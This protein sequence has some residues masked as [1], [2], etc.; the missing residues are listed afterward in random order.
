VIPRLTSH[1]RRRLHRVLAPLLT[2]LVAVGGLV[3]V[4]S[5]AQAGEEAVHVRTVGSYGGAEDQ[6][7]E[8]SDIAVGPNGHVYVAD[9]DKRRIV[10]LAADGTYLRSV[11]ANEAVYGVDVDA[12]GDIY[13]MGPE[14]VSKYASSDGR[15]LYQEPWGGYR[16]FA[17]GD[18]GSV[19]F[20][21]DWGTPGIIREGPNGVEAAWLP[22]ADENGP[23]PSMSSYDV[24]LTWSAGILHVTDTKVGRVLRVTS[25][26]DYVPPLYPVAPPE[27]SWLT[28]LAV[29]RMGR[30]AATTYGA[31]ATFGSDWQ[32][33]TGWPISEPLDYEWPRRVAYG[34]DGLVYTLTN[35]SRIQITRVGRAFDDFTPQITGSGRAGEELTVAASTAPE[36]ASWS[37]AWTVSGS[38]EVR[39]TTR[40]FTPTV[41]DV[42]RTVSVAVTAKGTDGSPSD[43]TST[44]SRTVAPAAMT[45]TATLSDSTPAT[46]PTTGDVLSVDLD[47]S[48]LPAGATSAIRWGR[49]EAG[50]CAVAG[51]AHDTYTVRDADA[52]ATLCA[53]VTTKAAGH[54]DLVTSVAARDTAI[55]TFTVPSPSFDVASP[56]VGGTVTGSLDLSGAPAGAGVSAWRWGH[57]TDGSSCELIAGAEGR[58]FTPDVSDFEKRLCVRAT[59]TAPHHTATETLGTLPAVAAGPFGQKPTVTVP[60]WAQVGVELEGA[61]GATYTPRAADRGHDLS[62]TVTSTAHGY[63]D[64]VTTSSAVEVGAGRLQ[65]P[66]PQFDTDRPVVGTPVSLAVD[67]TDAPAGAEVERTWGTRV[68]EACEPVGGATGES[69]TPTAAQL[70][71]PLCVTVRVTAPGYEPLEATFTAE[72]AVARGMLPTMSAIL[73]TTTPEVGETLTASLVSGELPAGASTRITW[74]HAAAG[75]ECVADEAGTSFEVARGMGG[76]TVCALVTVTAPGY[77]EWSTRLTAQVVQDQIQGPAPAFSTDRPAVGVPVSLP[78]DLTGAPEG[79]QATRQ[80]GVR[81]GRECVAIDGATGESF[82][83]TPAQVGEVLCADVRVTAADHVPFE[84]TV[85]AANPVVR[86]TLPTLRA[87]LSTSSPKVGSTLTASVLSGA[88]PAGATTTVTWG[89]AAAGAVCRP[90][91]AA[92]SLTMTRAMAGNT[93]CALVKVT[94]PG[95]AEWTTLLKAGPVKEAAKATSSRKVVR[96]TD[97]FVVRAQGLAPGQ[98][99]RI[100]IRHRTFTGTAD[101]HGRLVRTVR[102]GK[103]LKSGKRTVIVRGFTGT[104][105]TYAKRFTITYRAR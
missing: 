9:A 61:T 98:R 16:D 23:I 6:F 102:Y 26:G 72:H 4:A 55:G 95:Y 60:D 68:G 34:D 10:E 14:T 39:S 31:T 48:T 69:F 96:G 40:S 74:G 51:S 97:R 13:V 86:G 54:E 46:A 56:V 21:A 84:A 32:F 52:G 15:R 59:V 25:D 105:V 85:S 35:Y 88:L 38:D 76:G 104:K 28:S 17:V 75:E 41:A 45:A 2:A 8:A 64:D 91:T 50:A 83:P 27:Y 62:V 43:R 71:H 5:P 37:Y 47:R 19:Y 20:F 22:L 90:A 93:V 78:L 33:R 53:V 81:A 100:S 29:D 65:V 80:W 77:A 3:S 24:T 89:R 11:A 67:L 73:S 66:V 42:G 82:T 79:A 30:F 49:M 103:G 63:V 58:T 99:Y 101:S 92:R 7:G 44:A 18:D 70:G 94:A 36:P 57:T 12:A 87:V 1:T